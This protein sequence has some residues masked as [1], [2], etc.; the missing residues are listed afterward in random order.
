VDTANR[1]QNEGPNKKLDVMAYPSASDKVIEVLN[2]ARER[3]LLAIGQYM[4]QHYEL[5]DVGLGKLGHTIK[6][7]AIT[8]MRHAEAFAER[9]LFL[10]GVPVSKPA[11]SPSVKQEIPTILRTDI[12]LESEAVVEYNAA[13]KICA[14]QGDNA[15]RDLFIKILK[16]EDAHLDEF[17]NTLDHVETMGAA[18]LATQV[19]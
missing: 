16:E 17:Q 1:K 6:D 13:A 4:L 19:D 14:E 11:R 9:I 10:G 2:R 7:I 8:E 12:G 3:E 15:S 5:E 18:Y